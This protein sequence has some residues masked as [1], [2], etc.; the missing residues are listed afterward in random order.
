MYPFSQRMFLYVHPQ[1]RE[2][3]KDFAKFMAT[4]GASTA[5]RPKDGSEPSWMNDAMRGVFADETVKAV[6]ETY[7]K[8]GLIPLADA[9]IDRAAKDAEA[10]AR[11]K[12]AADK[13][14][15]PKGK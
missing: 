10:A 2:T 4:C 9:A 11:A 14:P 7:A 15:K 8:H 5:E 1:A 12:E 6:M 3:A 13:S